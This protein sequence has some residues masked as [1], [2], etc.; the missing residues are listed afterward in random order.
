MTAFA[1][2]GVCNAWSC[3]DSCI[4]FCV[5]CSFSCSHTFIRY[6]GSCILLELTF[7]LL[8][9]WLLVRG[10]VIDVNTLMGQASSSSGKSLSPSAAAGV[11]QVTSNS[12]MNEAEEAEKQYYIWAGYAMAAFAF[13][14]LC[15][16]IFL[17][18]AIKMAIKIIQISTM[19]MGAMPELG[20][21]N[22]RWWSMFHPQHFA[23]C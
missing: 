23:V 21:A 6:R 15:C 14:W 7:L 4:Y 3:A 20:N 17:R 13:I 2:C 19:A 9:P 18:K 8:A 12:L 10:G 22:N 5:S 16:L 11:A 1:L